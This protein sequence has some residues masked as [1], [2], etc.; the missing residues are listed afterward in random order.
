MYKWRA[1]KV[2]QM[3]SFKSNEKEPESDSNWWQW[4]MNAEKAVGFCQK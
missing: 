2:Q 4:I 1:N 3:G